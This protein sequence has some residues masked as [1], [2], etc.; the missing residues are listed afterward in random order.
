MATTTHEPWSPHGISRLGL[1]IDDIDTVA[2][3]SG[4]NP[5]SVPQLMRTLPSFKQ[6]TIPADAVTVQVILKM[7]NQE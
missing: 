3:Y 1:G 7:L 4:H 6:P 5:R 2:R